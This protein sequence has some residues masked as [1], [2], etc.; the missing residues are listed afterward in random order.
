MREEIA[1][2][3]NFKHGETSG[4]V[5]YP[6]D[7][8]DKTYLNDLVLQ[9]KK[10]GKKTTEMMYLCGI[11][12]INNLKTTWIKTELM[13]LEEGILEA[14]ITFLKEQANKVNDPK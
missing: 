9:L 5:I 14:R 1:R 11:R 4:W 2:V 10:L 13:L 12:T 6:L 3:K 7:S 8:K